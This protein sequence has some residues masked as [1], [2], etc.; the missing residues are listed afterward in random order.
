MPKSSAYQ[1]VSYS[2]SS[3]NTTFFSDDSGAY[4]AS[5]DGNSLYIEKVA[6]DSISRTLTLPYEISSYLISQDTASAICFDRQNQQV[7]VFYYDIYSDILDSFSLYVITEHSDIGYALNR[8]GIYLRDAGQ[9][10]YVKRYSY[11]GRQEFY[12]ELSATVSC[13]TQDH[14]GNTY[15]IAN[16]RLYRL[17]PNAVVTFSGSDIYRSARFLSDDILI[18]QTGNV[19]KL[20]SSNV[21]LMF[22]APG[23][24]RSGAAISD[25]IYL[26][27]DNVVCRYVDGIKTQ[28]CQMNSGI[29]YLCSV[30]NE[31][32]AFTD[33]SGVTANR[34]SQDDFSSIQKGGSTNSGINSSS[35]D[36]SSTAYGITSNVYRIDYD[37]RVIYDIPSDTTISDF[38]DNV[39]CDGYSLKFYQDSSP[40]YSGKLATAM[41]ADFSSGDVTSYDLS[42]NGELTGEGNVNM[43]DRNAL[44]D[45]LLGSWS[46]SGAYLYAADLNFDGEIDLLDTVL[47][48]GI[49]D[50]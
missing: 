30:D 4:F 36:D 18:D 6:P 11:S 14:S 45:Y 44:M 9:A 25:G 13:I 19:M 24:G 33:E 8:N 39:S 15:A 37:N 28:S 16:N 29:I 10:N 48:C 21:E 40:R 23:L 42:I 7:V 34:L 5:S 46:L 35:D 27:E 1:Y 12:Y 32:W 41:T 26:F 43:K 49:T 38:K 50:N 20:S 3:D 22:R 17:E 31:I 2:R 47:I